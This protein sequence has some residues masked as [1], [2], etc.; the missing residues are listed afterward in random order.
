MHVKCNFE[1]KCRFLCLQCYILFIRNESTIV[2]WW[3]ELQLDQKVESSIL[4]RETFD[5]EIY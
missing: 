5:V 1:E 4:T 3:R 2:Y